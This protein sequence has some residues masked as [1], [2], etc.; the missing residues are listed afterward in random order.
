MVGTS[1]TKKEE[2]KDGMCTHKETRIRGVVGIHEKG[3]SLDDDAK[4]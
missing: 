2:S 1:I 4:L 3:F